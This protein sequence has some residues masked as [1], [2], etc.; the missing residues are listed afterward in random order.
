[1]TPTT[2]TPTSTPLDSRPWQRLVDTLEQAAIGCHARGA[3]GDGGDD[4]ILDNILDDQVI[5]LQHCLQVADAADAIRTALPFALDDYVPDNPGGL[6]VGPG[7]AAGS[8]A[9]HGASSP[10]AAPAPRR[11]EESPLVLMERAWEDL[12]ALEDEPYWLGHVPLLMATLEV[13]DALAAVR[14]HYE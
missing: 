5:W 6:T 8:A 12:E 2:D 4:D 14:T 3:S 10:A 9:R 7:A 13:A 1:M 11:L